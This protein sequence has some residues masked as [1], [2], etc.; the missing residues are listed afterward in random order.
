VLLYACRDVV[1]TSW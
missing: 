1:A